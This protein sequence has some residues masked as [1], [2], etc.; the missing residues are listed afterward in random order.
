MC[1]HTQLPQPLTSGSASGLSWR[2]GG[3]C[4]TAQQFVKPRETTCLQFLKESN[5][6]RR[7]TADRR[8][9]D[10]NASKTANPGCIHS[11]V[12]VGGQGF[13]VPSSLLPSTLWVLPSGIT[14]AD[15]E[16]AAAQRSRASNRGLPNA[17]P[18]FS[19]QLS[20][21]NRAPGHNTLTP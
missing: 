14:R 13:T 19:L 1:H 9:V 15:R 10:R 21:T 4:L 18:P 3:H 6:G 11:S 16:V 8:P 20:V 5:G 17:Q 12:R 2:G 7:C